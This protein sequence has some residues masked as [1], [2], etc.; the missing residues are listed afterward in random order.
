M[1]TD[2]QFQG[3]QQQADSASCGVSPDRRS[4]NNKTKQKAKQKTKRNKRERD[5][6]L[7]FFSAPPAQ[8]GVRPSLL[9]RP[10]DDLL[11][12]HWLSPCQP[13]RTYQGESCGRGEVSLNGTKL[14]IPRQRAGVAQANFS[15]SVFHQSLY[16]FRLSC[17]EV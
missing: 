16:I 3:H 9:S 15:V 17:S 1:Q 14:Q 12:D 11:T 8:T 6:R 2:G 5:C 10:S 7:Q 13:C 4:T